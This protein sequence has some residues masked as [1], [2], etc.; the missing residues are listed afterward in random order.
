M[1]ADGDALAVLRT[2]VHDRWLPGPRPTYAGR[3][4]RLRR[5]LARELPRAAFYAPYA[6]C[7]LVDLPVVDKATV[8]D[9]FAEFNRHGITLDRA[10]GVATEAERTR[11]FSPTIDGVTV[12]LSSGTSGRRGVF[13][14]SDAERRRWAGTLMAQLLDPASVKALLRRPLRVALFLRANSNLYETVGGGRVRFDF[15]DLTRPLPAS[16]D[17]LSGTDVLIGPPSALRV[18]ADLPGRLRPLQVVSVAETLEPDDRARI[19]AA[20]GTRVEQVYQATEGLLGVSCPADR[21]HLN[22]SCVHVGPEWLDQ[23]RF[24]PVVT[25]FTRTTQYVVRYRLDDVLLADRP[26]DEPCRCGRP[27]RSVAAVLGRTGDVLDLGGV[28]VFAD[29][30]R[31][32]VALVDGLDDYRI[33]QR[34]D[35]W[36]VAVRADDPDAVATALRT[37]VA[38]LATRLAAAPPRW[39]P[40]A[41]PD[42]PASA[43]RRRVRRVAA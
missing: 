12:G 26:L 35:T 29:A 13:L 6:G 22:E 2:L 36:H 18:L 21:V 31:H 37:E 1:T 23:H 7:E 42:E 32:A 41:W 3:E 39:E 30:L 40:M 4:R 9:R 19:A 11:D 10:L 43:K 15:H 8:L 5:F 38:R 17:S 24:V 33:E 28:P 20:F 16:L 14:V 25:D 34:G 27:G